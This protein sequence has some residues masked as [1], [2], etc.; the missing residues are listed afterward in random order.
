[1]I[2]ADRG[3]AA[4]ACSRGML[5]LQQVAR[6]QR[7]RR[8]CQ[9][10]ADRKGELHLEPLRSRC[11]KEQLACQMHSRPPPFRGP[12]CCPPVDMMRQRTPYGIPKAP[13]GFWY[14]G[15]QCDP[16]HL[17]LRVRNTCDRTQ[18]TPNNEN[19]WYSPAG[20]ASLCAETEI[21]PVRS[22]FPP[23]IATPTASKR[24]PTSV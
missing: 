11:R 17:R 14:G 13:R 20:E 4:T 16:T 12:G 19:G 22:C 10:Q 3:H 24:S 2:A 23:G 6:R 9:N 18:S 5:T 21:D 8:H 1:M 7:G 15:L